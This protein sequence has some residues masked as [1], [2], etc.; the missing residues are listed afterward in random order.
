VTVKDGGS[1]SMLCRPQRST[2]LASHRRLQPPVLGPG[3]LTV[4]RA[5]Q[6]LSADADAWER[7]SVNTSFP[8]EGGGPAASLVTVHERG[9]EG[10]CERVAGRGAARPRP[11]LGE[12]LPAL[13][14]SPAATRQTTPT[15]RATPARVVRCALALDAGWVIVP[16]TLGSD[17]AG[18]VKYMIAAMIASTA[19][20]A[21]MTMA[22]ILP[23]DRLAYG[24]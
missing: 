21:R 12:G 6:E 1:L 15:A 8:A 9:G 22:T 20:T 11:Y 2:I 17:L 23:A 13:L 24:T 10:G 3:A 16:R 18:S 19:M 5:V 7:T 14:A 4:F